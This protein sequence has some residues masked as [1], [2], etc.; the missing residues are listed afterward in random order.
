MKV[1][2]LMRTHIVKIS[3][4]ATVADAVD[5]MDLYQLTSLAVVDSDGFP[6]G[7]V[8][9][10]IIADLVFNSPSQL[11]SEPG[12][13]EVSSGA[14]AMVKSKRVFDVMR[15]TAVVLDED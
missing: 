13:R 10:R 14:K 1:V 12:A 9:D 11:S 6:I 5:M 15:A 2:E 8:D 3:P 4:E 7:V